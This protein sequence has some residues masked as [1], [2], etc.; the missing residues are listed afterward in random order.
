[1]AKEHRARTGPGRPLGTQKT[2]L[3]LAATN[4]A[5]AGARRTRIGI[6]SR[7]LF[8]IA[9]EIAVESNGSPRDFKG[10]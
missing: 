9:R 8:D 6:I 7:D 5:L 10:K 1:M 3:E 4:E 2:A